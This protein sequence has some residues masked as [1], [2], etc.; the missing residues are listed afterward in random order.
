MDSQFA[1]VA[2]NANA[3]A[4]A[5]NVT[6]V[7]ISPSEAAFAANNYVNQLD[8][9]EFWSEAKDTDGNPSGEG[10]WSEPGEV[11]ACCK[12]LIEW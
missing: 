2:A 1:T 11:K 4:A 10:A 5:K 9:Y 8:N 12:P 7:S 6:N 3:A